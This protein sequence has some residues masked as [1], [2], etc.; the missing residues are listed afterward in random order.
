MPNLVVNLMKTITF[1]IPFF[2]LVFNSKKVLGNNSQINKRYAISIMIKVMVKKAH[3]FLQ[4]GGAFMKK[5]IFLNLL[6]CYY[7]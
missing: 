5:V 4:K 2:N 1:I 3:F 7:P 6:T